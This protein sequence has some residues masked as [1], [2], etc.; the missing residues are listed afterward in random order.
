MVPEAAESKPSLN[1]IN[2]GQKGLRQS[3]HNC[4]PFNDAI[5]ARGWFARYTF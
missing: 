3:I 5:S 4:F 2:A 1:R